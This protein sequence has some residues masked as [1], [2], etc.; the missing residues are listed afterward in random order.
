HFLCFAGN[1]SRQYEFIQYTWVNNPKFNGLYDDSDP[2]V[3]APVADSPTTTGAQ[4]S[5]CPVGATFTMQANPIRARVKDV[6]RFVS[7]RGGAYF[8]MPGIKALR[9]LASLP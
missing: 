1:I 8:F 3:G 6:P 5:R 4:P 9:Y 2:L 7:V